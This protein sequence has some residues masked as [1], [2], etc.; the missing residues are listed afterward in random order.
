MKT[1]TSEK[2][3]ESLIVADMI[4]KDWLLGNSQDYDREYAV[5]LAQLRTFL[6][7]TQKDVAEALEIAQSMLHRL[8]SW[9][10]AGNS[11]GAVVVKH[12]PVTTSMRRALA[13]SI[14]SDSRNWDMA[15]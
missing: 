12:A 5:D 1:D 7:A 11:V 9:G 13:Q 6:F 2:G 3:L 8:Q 14:G 10:I 15:R 4:A